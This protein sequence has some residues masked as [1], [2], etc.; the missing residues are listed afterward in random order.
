MRL[1]N[2]VPELDESKCIGC[3]ICT[4]VCP[5]LAWSVSSATRLA[6]LD[7]PLCFGCVNCEARCPTYAIRMVPR[8]EDRTLYVDPSGV[9]WESVEALCRAARMHP[10]QIICFCTSSRAEEAA[11]A[12]LTGSR[13]AEDISARTGIRS[14]CTVECAQPLLR[15]LEAAGI[16][17]QQALGGKGWQLYGKVPT[18]WE[19]PASVKEKYARRGFH[20]EEDA[21]LMDEIADAPAIPPPARGRGGGA[22]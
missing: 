22:A 11:A 2:T 16:P 6:V 4:S 18:L 5:T 19:I 7:E 14:G 3:V 13:T 10:E 8:R 17:H 9:P 12:I 21:A 15:L 20:F 1:V